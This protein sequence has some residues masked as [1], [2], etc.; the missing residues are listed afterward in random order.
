[1]SK[2]NS[3]GWLFRGLKSAKE[4]AQRYPKHRREA[5]VSDKEFALNPIDDEPAKIDPGFVK[6]FSSRDA[7]LLAVNLIV[8]HQRSGLKYSDILKYPGF[9]SLFKSFWHDKSK[10][11]LIIKLK[12]MVRDLRESR[13]ELD[14]DWVYAQEFFKSRK[15]G[16]NVKST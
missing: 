15:R 13:S 9:I 7:A 4:E 16:K 5:L 11:E 6:D 1:M 3:E 10:R 12:N 8:D 14:D 2:I